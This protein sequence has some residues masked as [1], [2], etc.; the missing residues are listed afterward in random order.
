MKEV[1]LLDLPR[2]SR[3]PT[4]LLGLTSWERPTRTLAKVDQEY[5]KGQYARLL[6][7][8]DK[9]AGNI[10]PDE[11]EDFNYGLPAEHRMCVSMGDGLFEITLAQA[12]QKY[13][14][15]LQDSLRPYAQIGHTLIEL[16]AGYGYNLWMLKKHLAFTRFWGGEY[17]AN[18]VRLGNLLY[19]HEP[20][21]KMFPFNYYDPPSY[22]ILAEAAQPV[23]LFTSH[24]LEQIPSAQPVI[25][26]LASYRDVIHKVIHFEPA[27]Q[28]YDDSLLGQMRSR[29][30]Q[31][32]NYNADLVAQLKSRNDIC[33][34]DIKANV[35]GLNVLNPAS[36]ITWSFA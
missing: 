18:A 10:T 33:I 24:S 5:D 32:N 30:T 16:G 23:V 36:V 11:M 2:W 15:L 1:S 14:D 9:A 4:R 29:Y 31:L 26:A 13:Y 22:R 28:L 17:S 7:Y 19:S 25:E 6:T 35:L 27:H 34:E 3:W 21:I 8:Y 20:A 12:R